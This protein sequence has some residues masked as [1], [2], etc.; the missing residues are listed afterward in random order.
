MSDS[1]RPAVEPEW[2]RDATWSRQRRLGLQ[3]TPA[4][5]LAW[6]EEMLDELLPLVGRAKHAAPPRDSADPR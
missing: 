5:R 3:M 2:T 1:G 4:Q 6:L